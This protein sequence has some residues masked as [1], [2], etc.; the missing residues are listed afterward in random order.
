M[1]RF[2]YLCSVGLTVFMHSAFSLELSMQ[3]ILGSEPEQGSTAFKR[4]M[5][6]QPFHFPRD[7]LSHPEYQTEWWYFSGNLYDQQRQSRQAD[8][9]WQFTLF[10]FALTRDPDTF[11]SDQTEPSSWRSRNIY[12]AHVALTDFTKNRYLNQ[13]RFSR[14]GADLAGAKQLSDRRLTFWLNDWQVQSSEA[15][16]LFPLT[17]GINADV[18]SLQ[19]N[20]DASKPLVLQGEQGLS[21][22]SSAPGNASYYYSY[23]RLQTD[24]VIVLDNKRFNVQGSSWLDREWSTSSLGKDQQGWDWFSL[25]LSDGT[26]IMLYQMRKKDNSKDEYSKGT[27]ISVSGQSTSLTASDFQLQPL[28][29]W[30]SPESQIRYPVKWRLTIA[31]ESID[32]LVSTRV[33]QQEWTKKNGAS[34]DY[35]EGG[36][37]FTG[38]K[39]G[40]PVSGVGYLEMTG[41]QSSK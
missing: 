10:R 36:I 8:Y 15:D 21:Q 26:E 5:Q 39:D 4:A 28:D 33:N 3:S 37:T 13:E 38:K 35:W 41:Y 16:E 32:V 25:Q 19:L 34:F 7:H 9:A 20:I 17:L 27:L 6:I 22:K 11:A 24:G 29:Y 1:I 12:M 18:F 14:D 30:Q 40:Q 23:T 2:F 31:K